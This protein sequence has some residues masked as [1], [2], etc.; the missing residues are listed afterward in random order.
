MNAK[1]EDYALIGD[2]ETAA[3]VGKD[4]SVDWLCLP[5]FDSPACFAALLGTARNGFWRIAPAGAGRCHHRSYRGDTLVLDTVWET[6]EGTVRVTDFMPPRTRFPCLVRIVEGL[7]GTVSLRSEL[8]PRFHQGRI[9]PWIRRVDD[10]AVAVAGPDAIWLRAEFPESAVPAEFPHAF[11]GGEQCVLSFTVPA[12]RRVALRAAWSPSHLGTPPAPL[13]VP[14][15]TALKETDGFWRHWSARCR[16]EGPWRDAVVRS[17]VTL[18]ALT[19]AP[20]GGI[21]A[22]PTTSL[23]EDPGGGRNRDHRHCWLRDSAQTLSCLLRSGY[24][25]EATAWLDW[26]LRAIA[27]DPARL[28]SVY[29][30][31]GERRMRETEA[32]WLPGYEDSRPVRFGS[33]AEGRCG[34]EVYGEILDTLYLSLRAGIPLPAHLWTLTNAL[35]DRLRT[36]WREADRGPWGTRGPERQYTHSK[37]MVWVAADRALRLGELL[38]RNGSSAQWRALRDAVHRQV[39]R[40]GWDPQQG[41]FV[42][43]YGSRDVDA[44]ALLLPALGFLPA[45]DPRVR[46]TVRAL[47]ALDHDGFTRRYTGDGSDGAPGAGVFV[48][49]SLWSADAA[50]ATGSPEEARE[51]FERVLGVRNDVGLLAGQWDPERRRHLGNA[52]RA[53]SHIALV[54]TAFALRS[55]EAGPAP[56]TPGR[57]PGPR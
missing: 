23:P 49:C 45:G 11:P 28:Q 14:A 34:L 33:P 42:R 5:R 36:H 43:S 48:P 9:V 44:S 38:G 46:G 19:Y 55:A 29:G 2:M 10:C 54:E 21:V 47:H 25:E 3:L 18:K 15:A 27:G 8:A 40:E 24:R 13:A 26:L 16:Y 32:P 22:A 39:C 30:V 1:I 37:V 51:R 17:L 57:R 6:P 12:G 53:A 35:M 56:V 7:S 41:T 4:G 50:A 20:T 31:S 52:P